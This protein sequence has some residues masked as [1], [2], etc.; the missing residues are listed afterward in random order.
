MPAS[1]GQSF[2]ADYVK[3]SGGNYYV[4]FLGGE[5][6]SDL[7]LAV[8]TQQQELSIISMNCPNT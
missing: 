4:D 5:I 2:Y 7:D 1:F 8:T 3:G 6:K